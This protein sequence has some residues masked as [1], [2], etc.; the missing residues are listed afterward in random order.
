M[1]GREGL[2]NRDLSPL[3]RVLMRVAVEADMSVLVCVGLGRA[4][5]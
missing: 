1:W 5:K 2:T 4:G 3:E